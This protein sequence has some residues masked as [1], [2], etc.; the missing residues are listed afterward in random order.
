VAVATATSRLATL[1]VTAEPHGATYNRALFTPLDHDLRQL[2][3]PRNRPQTR[4]HQRHRRRRLLPDQRHL[5]QS[6]GMDS[7]KGAAVNKD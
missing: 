5:A 4:R 7:V 1:T 2:Q 3:H 6:K